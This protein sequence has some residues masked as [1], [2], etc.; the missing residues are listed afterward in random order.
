MGRGVFRR[1][2]VKHLVSLAAFGAGS[3]ASFGRKKDAGAGGF[4]LGGKAYAMDNPDYASSLAAGELKIRYMGMSCFLITTA[5][6]TRIITDPF[7][8]DRQILHPELRKAPAD[9]VTVSCGNYAHCY[10]FAVGGM[11]YVYRVQAP[12]DIMGITFRGVS[13]RHLE[14]KDVGTTRPG[15]NMVICFEAEGIRCC[16]LGALGHRLSGAQVDEI[17][18][19]DV[20]MVPVGGVST[21][22]AAD[23][24][25]VCA[26]LNPRIILPMHY[27]SERCTYDGWATVDDFLDGKDNAVKYSGLDEMVLTASGLPTETKI[28]ALAYGH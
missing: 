3:L 20:L 17:G 6:G 11:P 25:V 19:V 12:T 22:P 23:I 4:R 16:H 27:R 10:V 1:T 7:H 8:G 18:P 24:D 9:V 15:E 28:V 2:F 26:Q 21:L 5:G 14:M 13:T